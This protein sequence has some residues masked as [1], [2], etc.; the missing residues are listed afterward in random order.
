MDLSFSVKATTSPEQ[1]HAQGREKAP[2]QRPSIENL[3]II[4]GGP[5]GFT[6]ALYAARARLTP[7]V[8]VGPAP[9]GQAATTDLMENFPG[10]PEGI[11]GQALASLMQEQCESFGAELRVEEVTDVDFTHRPFKITTYDGEYL[12]KTL[13]L[14]TGARPLAPGSA[15][16]REIHRPWC[17]VLRDLRWI[18]LS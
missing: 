11:G 5:A 8:L 17:L 4:G 14:A 10:F 12:A 6:A 16:R 3:L 2:D 13:I 7:L 1:A 18:L 15:R 9:G